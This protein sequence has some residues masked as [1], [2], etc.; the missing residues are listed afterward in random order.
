MK[1]LLMLTCQ[2]KVIFYDVNIGPSI[3]SR[4]TS[5]FVLHQLPSSIPTIVL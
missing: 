1:N 2:Y 4:P 5:P 3:K